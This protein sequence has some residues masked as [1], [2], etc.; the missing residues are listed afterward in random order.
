ML[1]GVLIF[2]GG[3]GTL[4]GFIRQCVQLWGPNPYPTLGKPGLRKHTLFKRNLIIEKWKKRGGGILKTD[5]I[6]GKFDEITPYFRENGLSKSTLQIEWHPPYGN[7]WECNPP[8]PHT[9]AAAPP[10]P[11]PPPGLNWGYRYRSIQTKHT[12][13]YIYNY[14]HI[15]IYMCVLCLHFHHL[16]TLRFQR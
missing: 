16:S 15:H 13:T 5:L 11:P 10:P 4:S 8:P 14:I 7:W 12:H 3:G 2:R 1:A 6:W 9:T